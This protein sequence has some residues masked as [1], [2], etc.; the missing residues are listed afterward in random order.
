M[1]RVALFD[2]CTQMFYLHFDCR[3]DVS[4]LE[5]RSVKMNEQ[6]AIKMNY[7]EWDNKLLG[8]YATPFNCIKPMRM[9]TSVVT[10]NRELMRTKPCKLSSHSFYAFSAGPTNDWR[11][12]ESRIQLWSNTRI[13]WNARI[14]SFDWIRPQNIDRDSTIGALETKPIKLCRCVT[15]RYAYIP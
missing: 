4:G 3:L 5:R 11:L 14:E 12:V 7:T 13:T 1:R 8:G 10:L 2:V 15:L 9:Y 6:I